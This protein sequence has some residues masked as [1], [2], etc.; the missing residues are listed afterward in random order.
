VLL[1]VKLE[2]RRLLTILDMLGDAGVEGEGEGE[3]EA[4]ADAG[5]RV[6]GDKHQQMVICQKVGYN[7]CVC[8]N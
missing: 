7:F 2:V 3:E 6:K 1:V 5:G 4:E 8:G